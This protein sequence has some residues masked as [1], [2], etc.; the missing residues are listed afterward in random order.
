[1]FCD[2]NVY[3]LTQSGC[4]PSGILFVMF[5]MKMFGILF[6]LFVPT[7]LDTLAG[8]SAISY[9]GD[10][11]FDFMFAFLHTKPFDFF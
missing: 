9:K 4:T 3:D 8:I 1:M 10:N 11:F 2:T 7:G 6:V 5:L